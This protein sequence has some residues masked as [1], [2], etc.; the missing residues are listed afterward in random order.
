MEQHQIRILQVFR[1]P[2]FVY[3]WRSAGLRERGGRK[4]Y[5]NESDLVKIHIP[6][7][8]VA[9]ANR[10]R[11]P[12][13]FPGLRCISIRPRPETAYSECLMPVR[14][15]MRWGFWSAV[16]WSAFGIMNGTQVVVGMRAVGMHHPWGRLFTFHA[17]SWAVWIV[18]TPLVL[19]LGRRHPP[20]RSW[21]VHLA[22]Y[23]AIVAVHVCWV[24]PLYRALDP[25][26][27]GTSQFD[28]FESAA[29][30]FY[31]Q[32]HVDLFVYA[33]LLA[34][35]HLLESRR[36]LSE[37]DEQLSKA[38]LEALRRQLQPHFLFNTLNGIV[39]LVRSGKNDT[40]VQM[41]AGL[42]DLLRRTVEGPAG[43]ETTLAEELEFVEKY[44][45]IQR[46][47]F[48]CRLRFQVDVPMDLSGARVP[49]MILQP[50]V[51]NA[52]EHGVGLK[53]EGGML[54]ISACRVNG[55]LSLAVENDGPAMGHIREGVGISNTRERLTSMYGDAGTFD[56]HNTSSQ[57]VEAV[58][59]VPYRAS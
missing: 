47:R 42:S 16:V 39:G 26:G 9:A 35:A 33:C 58:V 49:S 34:L 53:L 41:I 13:K 15:F 59:K 4:H 18:A 17:L 55:Q 52:I 27:A 6:S 10:Q 31:S 57:T 22:A 1:K 14:E 50:I 3:Q 45:E 44:L 19:R 32:F 5:E 38:R 43:T 30:F 46:M 37:R 7:I 51:E 21:P 54:R 23:I 2:A 40:A 8:R 29:S 11:I 20:A 24:I 56:L 12:C 36:T 28:L 48:A 25:L